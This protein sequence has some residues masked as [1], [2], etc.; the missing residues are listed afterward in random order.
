MH[1]KK[2]FKSLTLIGLYREHSEEMQTIIFWL[3]FIQFVICVSSL[4]MIHNFHP[5]IDKF[6]ANTNMTLEFSRIFYNLC[7][8][9]YNFL[10]SNIKPQ[11]I[12]DIIL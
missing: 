9:E 7:L 4:R 6:L 11:G 10:T 12:A 5:H 3:E 2:Y 8:E 1:L